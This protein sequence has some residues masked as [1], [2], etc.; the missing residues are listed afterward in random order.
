[1]SI[2]SRAKP[3]AIIASATTVSPDDQA[4]IQRIKAARRNWQ[5]QAA[6]LYHQLAELHYPANYK[7]AALSRFAYPVGVIPE[8]NK[9]S[10]PIVLESGARNALD[11]AAEDAMFAL[12]GPLGG[13]P[14]MARL[15][16]INMAMAGD[17]W[18]VGN[19][20]EDATEW[21]FLSIKE[22]IA[23][24]QGGW[25][26]NSTGSPTGPA[27]MGYK[28]DY[29]K[30]FWRADPFFTQVADSAMSALVSDCQ[31]LVALNQSITSRLVTRLAQ[32]GILF[33]DSSLQVPGAIEAPTG[34]GAPVSDPFYQKFLNTLESAIL[35]RASPAGSIPIIV[36]G[37]GGPQDLIK[38]ITMD[39]TI[40]RVEMELR[41]ELRNNIATGQ[42]LPTEAQQGLGDATHFQAWNVGDSTY[43]SHLLPEAQRWADGITRTYLWPALRAWNKDNGEKYG[44]ADIRRRV[45]VADGSAVITRPNRGQDMKDAAAIPGVIKDSYL[46]DAL[47]IPDEAKPDEE[48]ALR[49]M[50]RH[51]NNPY[52]ATFGLGIHDRVDW[53]K[54]AATPAGEGRPGQGGTPPSKRPADPSDPTGAPGIK[55]GKKNAA[56]LYAAAASGFLAAATKTVGAKIRARCEPHPDVF[57]HV[58]SAANEQVLAR[59]ETEHLDA[60]GVTEEQLRGFFTDA[61]S[62]MLPVLASAALDETPAV[63][64]IDALAGLAGSRPTKPVGLAELRHIAMRVLSTHDS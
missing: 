13:M 5:L 43:S 20:R 7:G 28:P 57:A 19:D 62:P 30:R 46:R 8:G 12:E 26:R 42:D 50:G 1:M 49:Q 34:D 4:V 14:E 58:K 24:D 27:E 17:G 32:A 63:A 29:V 22:L 2:L 16:A 36:R 51:I 38:F 53:S 45:V 59:L 56:D 55:D 11:S 25:I 64:Y 40:D 9:D 41:A 23:T 44:E 15:Y 18:L 35:D 6:D 31:Q 21:E 54:V 3:N 47:D 60:I 39:R 61:L 10:R 33:L 37:Q 48:E 52:L